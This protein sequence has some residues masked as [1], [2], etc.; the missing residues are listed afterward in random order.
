M[1]LSDNGIDHALITFGALRAGVPVVPI[2]PA[3]DAPLRAIAALVRPSVVFARDGVASASTA[4]AIAPGAAFVSVTRGGEVPGVSYRSLLA[5]PPIADDP[6]IGAD[7]IAKIL[8]GATSADEARGVVIT[9]GMICASQQG[10]AQ[11]WPFLAERPPVLVDRSPWSGSFGGN[12]MLGIVLRNAGTLY[13]DDA[14]PCADLSPT[15][16]FGVPLAWAR[17]VERLRADDT[18]RRQ[19]LSRLDLA[20]WEA[21]TLAPSTRHALHAIG[22]GLA[23]A[24]GALQAGGVI[25][26]TRGGNPPHDAVGVPLAGV[27]LKLIPR[28]GT[29]EARVR[30][31]QVTPGYF[32]RPDLTAQAFDEEGFYRIGDLVRPIDPR[33]PQRGLAFVGRIDGRF[34]LGSGV[35]VP[36]EELREAFLAQSAPDVAA[37]V[38]TGQ[39]HDVVGLL[40]WPSEDGAL[41]DRDVLRAQIRDAMLRVGVQVQP[42]IRPRRALVM[43]EPRTVK[44]SQIARLYASEPDAEVIVL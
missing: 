21:A 11:A 42:G 4:R 20:V 31:P 19:W 41:L 39:G 10:I 43:D 28:A 33:A 18:L 9:H 12:E 37:V 36:A 2:S 14:G 8:F 1:I 27:E 26:V 34:R 23:S 5:H 29:Y 38:V 32:W 3:G 13:L 17:W 7:T 22:L 44:P 30:G 25:A 6:S 16:A 35:W 24:W 40:V 15:L